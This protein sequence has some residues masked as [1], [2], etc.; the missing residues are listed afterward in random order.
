MK[1]L[2]QG[3][4]DKPDD[5]SGTMFQWSVTNLSRHEL[6]SEKPTNKL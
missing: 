3:I 2:Q 4:A 6:I 1:R 5:M